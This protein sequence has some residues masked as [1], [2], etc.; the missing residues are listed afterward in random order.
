MKGVWRSRRSWKEVWGSRSLK[1]V[2]RSMR[3]RMEVCIVVGDERGISS[4]WC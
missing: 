1:G 3:S 4:S 2:W